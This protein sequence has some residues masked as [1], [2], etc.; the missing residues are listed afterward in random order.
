MRLNTIGNIARLY[1][2]M[3]LNE[4]KYFEQNIEINSKFCQHK[5]NPKHDKVTTAYVL[6]PQ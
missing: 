5:T 3:K 6:V 1:L 4:Y 2:P